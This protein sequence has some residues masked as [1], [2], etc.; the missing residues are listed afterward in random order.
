MPSETLVA[1]DLADALAYQRRKPEDTVLYRVVQH[2]LETFLASAREQGRVVPRFV[3]RELRAFL[4]CG[5]LCR[6]F[7]R[8]RCDDC[9]RE[10]LVAYSCKC[11]GFCP[12][13][14]ARRMADTAAHLVDRVF[15]EVPVRQYV[16]SL[17]FA[18]RY[19]IAFD[20]ELCSEVLRIFVQ[21]V[22]TSLRRRARKKLQVRKAYC[23]AVTFLQ[24]SGGSINLNPH[25]HSIILD[26]VYISSLPYGAPRFHALPPPTDE[27][28]ARITAA[29]ARR[30]EKLLVRKGLLG[31]D[32]PTDPDP[33][34]ADE[35]LLSQLYSASVQGRV[36]AGPRAG[37]RLLRL[38][39]RIDVEGAEAITGPRCASVQGFSLHADVCVPARDR[40][41]LER[42]V[43]Y[44]ARPPI[45]SERLSEL[46]D[47]RILYR[48]R[49][50]WRDGT[51]HVVFEPV[52]LVARLAAL[53]PPPRANIVRYH[54]IL[55]PCAS[56]RDVAV[57]DRDEVSSALPPPPSCPCKPSA[58]PGR[59]PTM[60]APT[61]DVDP[62]PPVG[63]P[64]PPPSELGT[65]G[66]VLPPGNGR[67]P[68]GPAPLRPRRLS[69]A[70]LL[71]RVFAVDAFQCDC[72]GRMRILAAIDSPEVARAILDC[73]GLS[74]RAPPLTPASPPEPTD[75]ELGFEEPWPSDE[76]DDDG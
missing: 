22:F 36:A 65:Q 74:S 7:L 41:R 39:D 46:P 26:G 43:R 66:T 70:Q 1:D 55:A 73:L 35:R 24:R 10:R 49:H 64:T 34:E 53:V 8:V 23:G 17:P 57:R 68:S 30:V 11:R 3:E 76:T 15:P 60:P 54:G 52:D 38:G 13:C 16:L 45:A 5:L 20:Q 71:R 21:S 18:L 32:A 12:S 47:G 29:I 67:G 25:F 72:G 75:L 2:N 42:L 50:R 44:G 28:I 62:S 14:G 69:W 31:E 9:G 19:R 40:R 51:T 59:A 63:R 48:L 61:E 58:A 4:D 6:G 56:W 37:Q 33:L 27:E